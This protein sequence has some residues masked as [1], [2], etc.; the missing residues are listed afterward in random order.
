MKKRQGSEV[1]E[2]E[3][4]VSYPE[5]LKKT[6]PDISKFMKIFKKLQVNIPF[7]DMVE[8][9]PR[10]TRYLKDIFAKK[11]KL[12]H[13]EQVAMTEQCNVVLT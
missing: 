2:L 11:R 10:Y 1:S 4:T 9:V 7:A 5:R 13:G 6:K 8:Q 12:P 3:K